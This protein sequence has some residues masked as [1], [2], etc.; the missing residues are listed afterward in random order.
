MEADIVDG[1]TPLADDS[2]IVI[3]ETNSAKNSYI[4]ITAQYQMMDIGDMWQ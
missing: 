3:L 1:I 4:I 2:V